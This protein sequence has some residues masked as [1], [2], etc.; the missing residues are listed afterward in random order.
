MKQICSDILKLLSDRPGLSQSKIGIEL[1]GSWNSS[2]TRMTIAELI[3]Q[4]L[5]TTDTSGKRGHSL[6]ISETGLQALQA[7]PMVVSV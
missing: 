4:G 7:Q 2:Y 3:H 5:I 6:T 1:S